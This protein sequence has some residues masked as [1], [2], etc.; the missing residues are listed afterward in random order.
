MPCGCARLPPESLSIRWSSTT[1]PVVYWGLMETCQLSTNQLLLLT[2]GS[3]ADL[4]SACFCSL[5]NAFSSAYAATSA[6]LDASVSPN[7]NAAAALVASTTK[8]CL[9]RYEDDIS[10]ALKAT[11]L[12]MAHLATIS[13]C[14]FV[15]SVSADVPSCIQRTLLG[16]VPSPVARVAKVG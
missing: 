15:T 11:G 13:E 4:C 7:S 6:E 14:P 12:S 5:F 9:A 8:A 3:T 2:A 16:Q 1:S 10:A